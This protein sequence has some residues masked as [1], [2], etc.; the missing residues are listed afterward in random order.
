MTQQP[1]PSTAAAAA[2]A[3]KPGRGLMRA[4]RT[5]LKVTWS[6]PAA[7]RAIRAMIIV[8]GL[9]A[10][11]LKVIGNEQFTVF[12]TFGAVG[13]LVLTTFGGSRRDKAV[14]HF[15][16][17][18]A[19]S[20]TLIIGT[21]VSGSV[22][23]AALATLPV[24]FAVCFAA[25]AGPNA[26][27]GVT[28]ALLAYVLPVA[29][30]GGPG[31]I[32]SRL[33]GWLL[34]SAVSTAGVLL[35]SPKSPGDQLRA[36]AAAAADAQARHLTAALAGTATQA[37]VDASLQAKQNLMNKFASTPYRPTGLATTDQALSSV[38]HMLEWSAGLS[39]D[40]L[41]GHLDLSAAAPQD[42]HVLAESVKALR[43]VSELLSGR[44]ATV[45]LPAIWHAR[46][47]SAALM[48]GLTGDH[49]RLYTGV[50]YAYHA[51]SI[52]LASS[53]AAAD[54]MIAAGRADREFIAR[55]RRHWVDGLPHSGDEP[56]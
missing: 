11:G 12:A 53:A 25:V 16:L 55:Q 38:I 10:L 37:D 4:M 3:P 18:V 8:P 28:G 17:A 2:G 44:N 51:Q 15:G 23:L 6:T 20:L 49:E 41:N 1:Q 33:A 47:A 21:L 50:S 27:S 46:A 7:A 36:L 42:K 30:A 39:C 34:A 9:F 14:A 56:V 43:A 31:L 40:A 26:A 52:G 32:P 29:T 19:G 35:L 48:C 5:D 13:T 54:A 22:W 45:D 24:T